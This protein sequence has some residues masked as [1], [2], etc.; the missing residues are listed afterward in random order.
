MDIHAPESPIHSL[1]DFAIHIAV[2]TVGILIALGLEGVREAVLTHRLIRETRT[3]FRQELSG[4]LRDMQ[5]ETQRIEA[6]EATLLSLA[7]QLPEL[8]SQ[9]PEQVVAA[10]EAIHDPNYFFATNS[11]QAALSSG[12]LAHLHT[13]EAAA[14]AWSA[15]GTRIYTALQ[16]DTR[17]SGDRAIAFW[18]AHPHPTPE[19]SEQGME[20][21]LL[22]ERN[23]S[24]LV[25]VAPQT[26]SGLENAWRAAGGH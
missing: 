17:V 21:V 16:N 23:Q 4:S 20:L 3:S 12:V 7:H 2:V 19:L 9:H 11:W 24:S 18:K 22:Y 25:Y 5:D 8:G 1:R 14:Y 26:R 15:E 10:L 6:G 13:D